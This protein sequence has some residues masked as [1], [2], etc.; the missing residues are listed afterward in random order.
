MISINYGLKNSRIKQMESLQE[1]GLD[2]VTVN[3]L[4]FIIKKW[5]MMIG[6]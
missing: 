2:V 3:W 1:G 6:Y 4:N 5:E